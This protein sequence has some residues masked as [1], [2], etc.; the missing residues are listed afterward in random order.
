M[1]DLA[2]RLMKA[3]M[4]LRDGLFPIVERRVAGF[5]IREGTTLV[6]YGCGPGRYT[7]RFAERTGP[8]GKV[9][10]VDTQELAIE[11]VARRARAGSIPNVF[12]VLAHGYRTGIPSASVDM[13]LALDMFFLVRDPTALLTEFRRIARPDGTLVLDDGHA[14]RAS[15]LRKIQASGLWRVTE[16]S[17]DHVRCTPTE[18]AAGRAAPTATPPTATQD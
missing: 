5:G 2:F 4:I 6:D 12:P 18:D 16:A 9:Y 10:A 17:R 14:S 8:A 1:S 13:I 3:A 15:T 7:V 11:S